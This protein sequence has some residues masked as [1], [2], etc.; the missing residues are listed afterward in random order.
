LTAKQ[1]LLLAFNL[2]KNEV[3]N[4]HLEAEL[5]VRKLSGASREELY[6]KDIFVDKEELLKLIELRKKRYPLQY[7]LGEVEF[8]SR[9]FIVKEGVFIPRPETEVLI[10]ECKKIIKGKEKIIDVGTGT[11]V[12]AI[13]LGSLFP[14]AKIFAVDINPMAIELSMENARLNNVKNIIFV[15]GNLLNSFKGPV[16]IIVSNPPYIAPGEDVYPELRYEPQE[17]YL[18]PPDGLFHIRKIIEMGRNILKRNGYILLEISPALSLRLKKEYPNSTIVKD[19][20]GKDRV[21]ILKN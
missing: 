3:E 19:L 2:L 11:G 10:E 8:Y 17:A 15:R 14:K 12:I 1:A 7:I 13:V 5:I 6:S 20:S 18:S 16:D 9:K 4:P 21:F